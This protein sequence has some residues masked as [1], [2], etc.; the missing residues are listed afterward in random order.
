MA[1]EAQL[2]SMNL[3]LKTDNY[4]VLRVNQSARKKTVHNL[5]KKTYQL[6][7]PVEDGDWWKH[8]QDADGRFSDTTKCNMLIV[9]ARLTAHIPNGGT[10]NA[11]ED[12]PEEAFLVKKEMAA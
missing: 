1:S 6:D 10:N 2:R 5:V 9:A 4:E 7:K 3:N 11:D 8:T 12:I